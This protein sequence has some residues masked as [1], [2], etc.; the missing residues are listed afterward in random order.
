VSAA[1]EQVLALVG[2]HLG[3]LFRADLAQRVRIGAVPAKDNQR[4]WRKRALTAVSSS[5]WA[6]T[7]TRTSEDQYQ[8]AIRCR[9]EDRVSLRRAIWTI[10]GRLGVTCGQRQGRTRG[11]ADQAERWQKQQRLIALEARLAAV[12]RQIEQGHPAITM[13]GRRLMTAR[14]HLENAGLTERQWR[15]RW[16]AARLFLTADGESGAPWGN[17]TITVD[18]GDGSVTLVLPEPLRH[19]ANSPRGRYR[20]DC[21]VTFHHRRGEWL[22]RA[23]AHRA[24][25]YDIVHDPDRGRW[26]LNA[27]WSTEVVTPP[28]PDELTKTGTRLLAVDLNADHLA[29]CVVDVHGNPVGDPHTIPLDLT[30]PASQRDGR[31]RTAITNLIQAAKQHHCAG[32]AIENLG[33]A[34]ARRTGRETMGRGKRGKSFRRTVH[35]IPTTRFRERLRGMA[36]HAGLVVVAVDPAYTSRWGAQHWQRPFQQQSKTRVT[37]HHSAAVAIGRRARGYGLRRRPGM[38]TSDQW[39][40][41]WR[42]TGQTASPPRA[43]AGTSPPRMPGTP[44]GAGQ[45][46]ARPGDQLALADLDDRSRGHRISPVCDPSANAGRHH[47]GTVACADWHGDRKVTRCGMRPHCGQACSP[48]GG[49]T[50][51]S[52]SSARRSPD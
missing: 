36:H 47:L 17:Y 50:S 51:G 33:F 2:G 40:A 49:S 5:R 43:R 16:D 39:I 52:T 12:E 20:L 21:G 30:G 26:Y 19:L 22:D 45:T 10:R 37:R 23:T 46:R 14:H 25:R 7:I 44:H 38:T 35:G 13:A 1:D 4:A 48:T 9:R 41:E 28:A 6:G 24:I 34:D 29:A 8:L 18:P 42:A 15:A 3:R 27:S 32:I 11:Y 31:L